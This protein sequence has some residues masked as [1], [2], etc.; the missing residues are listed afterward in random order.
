MSEVAEAKIF[1]G[2]TEETKKEQQ[3][4]MSPFDGTVVSTAPVCDV[5]DTIN[6]L[7][8]A[9]A[10]SKAAAKSPLSQRILWLEDVAN[11]LT[12]AKEDFALMLAKEVAKPI[13]FSRIEVERCVE[14]IKITAMELANLSGET[15]PTDIMP[16]G[17]KT[18]AYFRR[19]PVGV[20]ACITPFNFP[21]NLVAHKI[22]PALGAGNAVVLKPTPKHL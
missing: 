22:A 6:A 5:D 1:F 21:L 15:L 11:R 7:N 3:E 19:E 20:V 16:S 18:L 4:R 13:A 12:E 14:T 10:A 9:K 2:S 8:I 17:K